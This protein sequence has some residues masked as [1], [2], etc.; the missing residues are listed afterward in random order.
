MLLNKLHELQQMQFIVCEIVYL[1]N[2]CN[3]VT[4]M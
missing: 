3:L 4:I 1:Y 2:S